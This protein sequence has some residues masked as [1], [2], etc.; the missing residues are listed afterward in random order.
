V[1]YQPK[2]TLTSRLSAHVDDIVLLREKI[3]ASETRGRVMPPLREESRVPFTLER[4]RTLA[5]GRDFPVLAERSTQGVLDYFARRFSVERKS[6]RRCWT[7]K[8]IVKLHSVIASGDVIDDGAAGQ[9][10]CIPVRAGSFMP[11]PP[12]DVSGLMSGLLEWWN[13]KGPELPGVLTSAIVHYRISDIH[14][15]TDGN[16][17]LGRALALWELYRRGFDSPLVLPLNERYWGER[18]EYYAALRTVPRR[19]QDLTSW[20][21]YSAEGLR[22]ALGRVLRS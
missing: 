20:L 6:G 9:Y 1:S 19:A 18:K 4:V 3:L 2:F 5:N 15:F 21:E 12:G 7:H 11:P 14:P 17:R 10:R 8:D 16:G 13:T 22:S